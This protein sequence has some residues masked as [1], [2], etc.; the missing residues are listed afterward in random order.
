MPK[1]D[2]FTNALKYIYENKNGKYLDLVNEL[3]Q[4]IV[5]KFCSVGF[6]KT[7]YTTDFKTWGIT[8]L[9]KEYFQDFLL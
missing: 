6:I 3:S 5:D 4:E 8:S 1:D 7:G 9:G 2:E